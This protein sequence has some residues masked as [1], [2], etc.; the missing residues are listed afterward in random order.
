MVKAL[1]LKQDTSHDTESRLFRE[2]ERI[3]KASR[4]RPHLL[5]T[6][7]IIKIT[8][9]TIIAMEILGCLLQHRIY[10]HRSTHITNQKPQR[11][12]LF[13]YC[14]SEMLSL[15]HCSEVM[16]NPKGGPNA[17]THL[18]TPSV[19]LSSI[20]WWTIGLNLIATPF[21]FRVYLGLATDPD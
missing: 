11:N 18:K 7:A 19:T 1:K 17:T 14:S 20:S 9:Q 3:F 13:S 4:G 8:H 6:I 16:K 12:N 5:K 15:C 2:D 21:T 10:L